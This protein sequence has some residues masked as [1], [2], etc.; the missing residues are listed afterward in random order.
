MY[1]SGQLRFVFINLNENN[2]DDKG[3]PEILRKAEFFSF[4]SEPPPG[5]IL[6]NK[7]N[8]FLC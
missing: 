3:Y 1:I 4:Q 2:Q 8:S 7:F 5:A 6:L